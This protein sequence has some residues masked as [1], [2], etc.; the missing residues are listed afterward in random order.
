MSERS[1]AL[2]M[3]LKSGAPYV[4]FFALLAGGWLGVSLLIAYV[5]K[6]Y[7]GISSDITV[8]GFNILA[9]IVIISF[10]GYMTYKD[11]LEKCQR[12]QKT[13]DK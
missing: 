13:G 3:T 4:G 11:N 7:F 5:G 10:C 12:M 6:T 2:K 8:P 1:C 9:L